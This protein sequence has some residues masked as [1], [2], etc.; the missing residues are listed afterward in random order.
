MTKKDCIQ[1]IESRIDQR[2]KLSID[3]IAAIKQ[4]AQEMKLYLD[5]NDIIAKETA[6]EV[7]L[8]VDFIKRTAIHAKTYMNQIMD[9]LSVFEMQERAFTQE[10]IE[11]LDAWVEKYN[12]EPFLQDMLF[13]QYHLEMF[14]QL[15]TLI[16]DAKYIYR[17]IMCA[18]TNDYI[19]ATEMQ[20]DLWKTG[21]YFRKGEEYLE[22]RDRE[23]W[24][25]YNKQLLD[26]RWNIQN[27][28]LYNK[29]FN[30]EIIK[31]CLSKMG[32]IM[33]K[34]EPGTINMLDFIE[35]MEI[36][37]SS[38]QEMFRFNYH[39]ENLQSLDFFVA[40]LKEL[41]DNG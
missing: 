41:I 28:Y 18:V 23:R 22:E 9:A 3:D 30:H 6:K 25:F 36:Y 31:K 13:G 8:F 19:Y 11:Q 10:E 4:C 16:G 33:Y 5:A 34:T 15:N 14:R 40:S 26:S 2:E 35:I 24:K 37:H 39:E 7:L 20:Q 29:K 1:L 17:P 12:N 32:Q 21:A 27:N 38:T